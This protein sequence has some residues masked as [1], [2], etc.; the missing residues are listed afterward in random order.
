MSSSDEHVTCPAEAVQDLLNGHVAVEFATCDWKLC[1]THECTDGMFAP[2]SWPNILPPNWSCEVSVK[3]A[4]LGI[5]SS[6]RA[7]E[8]CINL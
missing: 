5:S 6:V 4:L 2:I 3:E 8:V 1:Q 7:P